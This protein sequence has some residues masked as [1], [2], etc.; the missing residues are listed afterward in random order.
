VTAC[1]RGPRRAARPGPPVRHCAL[2][3]A[4]PLIWLAAAQPAAAVTARWRP[5]LHVAQVVDLAGPRTDGRLVVATNGR[6]ALFR[7]PATLS[8]FAPGYSTPAG[9]EPYLARSPGQAVRGAGCRFP[10]DATYALEPQGQNGVI[11]VDARGTTRRLVNLA[12][13]GLLNG[14]AFDTTGRF[15]HR[16]LVTRAGAGRT[17]LFAIDCR[18]RA[19]SVT[20]SAPVL[21]GGIA[22]APATF[23]R[24]AGRLIAPDELSGRVVAIAADGAARVVAESGLPAGGDIGVES[25]GFVPPGLDERWTAYVADRSVPGNP[26][27]GNDAILAVGGRSLRRAGVRAGDLLVASEGGAQTIAVRCRAT[28][29]VRHVAD[30]PPT[31]HTEGHIVFALR[32]APAG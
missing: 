24:F 15:G 32:R 21:E 29:S 14:I 9:A 11:A 17:T 30:G 3:A 20:T 19:R 27:P 5:A 4:A 23:G 13:A 31:A 12:G 8:P 18:G 6:L 1:R 16:L 7:A 25:A 22:V 10:R 2:L 28:C 26:H